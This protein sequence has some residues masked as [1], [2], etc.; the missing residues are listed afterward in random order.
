MFL[1]APWAILGTE[2]GSG[3]PGMASLLL[4]DSSVVER[5][6]WRNVLRASGHQ[7]LEAP[8]VGTATDLIVKGSVE[9]TVCA[10]RHANHLLSE[11]AWAAPWMPL[12]CLVGAEGVQSG[13]ERAAILLESPIAPEELAAWVDAELMLLR[14]VA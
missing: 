6:R 5:R 11:L 14:A 7:V 13:M 12:I 1:A 2:T 4:L 8:D 3:V 9:L 10:G